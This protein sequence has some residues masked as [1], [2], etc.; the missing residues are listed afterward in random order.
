MQASLPVKDRFW[1]GTVTELG[2][3]GHLSNSFMNEA[4]QVGLAWEKIRGCLELTVPTM[5]RMLLV[6]RPSKL[7]CVTPGESNKK[8]AALTILHALMLL[9]H[10]H[11]PGWSHLGHW[12]HL[13][14]KQNTSSSCPISSLHMP[15][16]KNTGCVR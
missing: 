5:A 10:C 3:V 1:K 6:L 8:T 7:S 2:V 4:H 12:S 13:H 14:T 11:S 9:S 15:L 16:H